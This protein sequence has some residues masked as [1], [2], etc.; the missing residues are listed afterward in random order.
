MLGGYRTEDTAPTDVLQPRQNHRLTL[1]A[2]A[3]NQFLE[4]RAVP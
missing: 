2:R 3:R 1:S 4:K